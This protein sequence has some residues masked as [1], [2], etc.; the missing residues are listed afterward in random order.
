MALGCWITLLALA[1]DA[2]I[3]QI[4]TFRIATEFH[5][6]TSNAIPFASVWSGGEAVG[7]G[8]IIEVTG[9]PFHLTLT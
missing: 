7:T 6:T 1:F 4:V 8:L 2:F 3:Q 5:E 9:T